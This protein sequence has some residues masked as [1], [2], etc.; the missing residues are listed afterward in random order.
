MG[1]QLVDYTAQPYESFI[2]VTVLYVALNA[3]VL[4]VMRLVEDRAR[5]PG[6]IAGGG[7]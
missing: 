3:L 5:V 6:F 1:R 2:A 4:G 7:R